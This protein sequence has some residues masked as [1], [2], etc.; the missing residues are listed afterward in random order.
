MDALTIYNNYDHKRATRL[1]LLKSVFS[2]YVSTKINKYS[3]YSF[4]FDDLKN[5]YTTIPLIKYD[6]LIDTGY[7]EIKFGEF[8]KI[9]TKNKFPI[10]GVYRNFKYWIRTGVTHYYYRIFYTG[11]K[12]CNTYPILDGI[13]Q[14][15]NRIKTDIDSDIKKWFIVTETELVINQLF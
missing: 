9:L 5:S 15:I 8:I 6:E 7:K 10:E 13:D 4:T 3:F 1:A 11:Y 2:T 14:C 12:D